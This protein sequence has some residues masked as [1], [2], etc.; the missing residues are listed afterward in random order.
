MEAQ[1]NTVINLMKPRVFIA[2]PLFN[3]PQHEL[4]DNV[5]A[6]LSNNGFDYYSARKHSGSDKIPKDRLKDMSAWDPVFKS[7]E[8]GLNECQVMICVLEYAMPKGVS[9]VIHG[10]S[11]VGVEMLFKKIE[12][13][14]A[15]T[16]WEAGYH[17]A[18]GKL[19]IGF[20]SQKRPEHLNLMLTHG[21]DGLLL[22]Y[23]A[24]DTFLN[25]P[26]LCKSFLADT[27]SSYLKYAENLR[28]M[29]PFLAKGN[30]RVIDRSF[31]IASKGKIGKATRLLRNSCLFNWDSCTDWDQDVE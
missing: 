14:D 21:V 6:I 26:D 31:K 19:V 4:L 10:H 12:L 15:G 17:R 8:D 28:G 30:N 5:E 3:R 20:H 7:N 16:V 2:S 25:T 9:L 27:D 11:F 1:C 18:Q 22:G 23:E 29:Y 24:L 13:P